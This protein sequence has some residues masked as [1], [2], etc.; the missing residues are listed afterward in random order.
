MAEHVG[1]LRGGVTLY[2]ASND[3]A[4]A[5]SRTLNGENRAGD[6]WPGGPLLL[7][8]VETIDA[9]STSLQMFRLNHFYVA[10]SSAV[11]CDIEQ[12]L[13]TGLH[14][15]DART[16]LITSVSATSGALY[17]TFRP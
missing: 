6:T 13:H 9:T 11:L 17:Y 12:L 7:P 8:H 10:Q 2:A 1:R 4:L 16:R 14:P 5:A 3:L 15:P